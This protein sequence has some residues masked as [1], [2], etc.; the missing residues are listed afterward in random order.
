MVPL[1]LH[2]QV[3]VHLEGLEQTPVS[4]VLQLVLVSRLAQTQRGL[5]LS[6]Q[7]VVEVVQQRGARSPLEEGMEGKHGDGDY[8]DDYEL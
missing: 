3:H 4:P 2:V 1:K 7:L 5:A 8:G 6:V